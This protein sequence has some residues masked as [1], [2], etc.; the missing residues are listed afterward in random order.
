MFRLIP[1]TKTLYETRC[2]DSNG[3]IK[4]MKDLTINDVYESMT[5]NQ[6][7]AMIYVMQAVLFGRKR[8]FE[9]ESIRMWVKRILDGLTFN[10][11]KI[12]YYAAYNPLFVAINCYI[13]L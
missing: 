5:I 12:F 3:V 10:Q 11:K 6:R 13:Y 9:D 2:S 7:S 4:K 1:V 8:A